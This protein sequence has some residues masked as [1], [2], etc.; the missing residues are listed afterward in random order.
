[1]AAEPVTT[2]VEQV[3][4]APPLSG[5]LP[6]KNGVQPVEQVKSKSKRKS[7]AKQTSRLPK[8]VSTGSGKKAHPK[9]ERLLKRGG[10]YRLVEERDARWIYAAYKKGAFE[11]IERDL[12]PQAFLAELVQRS[13]GAKMHIAI[14][15]ERP[16]C[17]SFLI[18]INPNLTDLHAVWFPW[19]TPREVMSATARFLNDQRHETSILITS[20]DKTRANFIHMCKYGL[21]RLVGK[22]ENYFEGERPAH[23]FQSVRRK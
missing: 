3:T 15:N 5:D 18:P 10:Y 2:E 22:V 14:S 20:E 13:I 17:L 7:K 11:P 21:L 9:L 12:D 23:V 1:M 16:I 4:T 8:S 19:A 6:V